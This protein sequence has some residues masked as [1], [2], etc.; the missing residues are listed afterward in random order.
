[1]M[2]RLERFFDLRAHGTSVRSELIGGA[3]TF[4]TLSYIIFV[5]PAVLAT[6]GM[7]P[8]AVL[9][10]TCLASA[11]A[12]L[13]MGAGIAALGLGARESG[14]AALGLGALLMGVSWA[15]GHNRYAGTVAER[16]AESAGH[17]A[18]ATG[19]KLVVFGHTHREALG[20]GYANTGSFSF[21]RNAPG[22]PYVEIE[23][24]PEAPRA[25]TRF[26]K[27]VA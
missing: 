22:R 16:L 8:G 7:D 3:T 21:P 12:T 1:M 26:W 5:Q 25:V 20:D 17:V 19:A 4:V 15:N 11:I 14:A 10:A 13:S 18:K 9:T 6:T 23:G 24:S 27:A 2:S